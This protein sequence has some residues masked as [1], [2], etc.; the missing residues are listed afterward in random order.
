[1]NRFRYYF[2]SYRHNTAAVLP[3]KNRIDFFVAVAHFNQQKYNEKQNHSHILCKGKNITGKRNCR[4][5]HEFPDFQLPPDILKKTFVVI[6]LKFKS[7]RAHLVQIQE[8]R[9]VF[10]ILA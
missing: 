10:R 6:E 5:L 9:F 3:L 2:S 1:M 4:F 8:F 7:I